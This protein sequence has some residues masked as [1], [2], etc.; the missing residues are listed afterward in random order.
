MGSRSH[1]PTL[2]EAHPGSH[3]LYSYCFCSGFTPA[4]IPTSLCLQTQEGHESVDIA[5]YFDKHEQARTLLSRGARL[6]CRGWEIGCSLQA[7]PIEVALHCH[8]YSMVTFFVVA[9]SIVSP[10]I[11][12][13]LFSC[14]YGR[15][16]SSITRVLLQS[17][18]FAEALNDPKN[19]TKWQFYHGM[20][21]RGSIHVKDLIDFIRRMIQVSHNSFRSDLCVNEALRLSS[22]SQFHN[23]LTPSLMM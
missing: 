18:D 12:T 22:T 16:P 1:H 10:Q 20:I 13:S 23:I 7:L 8:H 17:D 9:G 3:T 19:D 5:A 14:K 2:A 11:F 21:M 15:V 6:N 4:C